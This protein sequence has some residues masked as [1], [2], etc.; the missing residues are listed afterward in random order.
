MKKFIALILALL[1]IIVICGCSLDANSAII[2]YGVKTPPV[3]ID[4]QLASTITELTIVKNIY[5]GLVRE[6][7][8]GDI[9]PAAATYEKSGNTYT[10][11]ISDTACWSNGD[12][13]TADDFLFGLTR[14]LDPTTKSP[15]ASSLFS[16]KN[17]KKYNSGKTVS[18]GI[19]ATT[20][21]TLKIELEYDDPNFLTVLTTAVA[22]PCQR[23]FFEKSIGKY[24]MSKDTVLSNGSF[25][26]T[27]WVTEDFA[28]RLHRSN[29]YGGKF[30]AN[31]AAIFLSDNKE[32]TTIE[33]LNDRHIDIGEIENNEIK[34]AT[35]SGLSFVNMPNTVW[36]LHIGNGYSA[37]LKNS[38]VS[39]LITYSDAKLTLPD[40]FY[41]AKRLYP[42]FFETNE[43]IKIYNINAA[44]QSYAQEIKKFNNATLPTSTLYYYDSGSS[45]DLIKMLVG[46][47]QQNL[48]A[49]INIEG[50]NSSAAV[51]AKQSEYS[52]T[53][54]SEQLNS[55]NLVKYAGF[56]G[57]EDTNN[58][59]NKIL[60]GNTLPIAY[61]GTV[62]AYTDELQNIVTDSSINIIDF[63]FANKKH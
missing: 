31:V 30:V 3:T 4:P 32:E 42:D 14:A 39:S 53:V 49:Y 52:L 58:L 13:L 35:E 45:A 55:A 47:W 61:S 57:F 34:A 54:Y 36:L 16:I 46:H 27:K 40:G 29:N 63:A 18:L 21:D 2:Y 56:F 51:K 43:E 60:S 17:A 38:F 25:K 37:A 10:F 1:N 15:D 11:K 28:M 24:G 6:D 7:E 22:M 9:V 5:E 23:D 62:I 41:A 19:S 8:N 44:K 48:G 59:K 33:R 12:K 26:L 50:L 20:D